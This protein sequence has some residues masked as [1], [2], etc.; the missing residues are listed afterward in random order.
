MKEGG[1]DLQSRIAHAFRLAAGRRPAKRELDVLI[2][3]WRS[4]H[5]AFAKQPGDAAKLT[6][7]GQ[8]ARDTSLDEL[9][10]AAHTVVCSLILNLDEVLTR[11]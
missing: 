10:L 3:R 4:V 6:S 9:E 8:A 11:S 2:A 5:R 1:A 7:V